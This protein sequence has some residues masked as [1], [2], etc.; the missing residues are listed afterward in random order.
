MRTAIAIWGASLLITMQPSAL[1]ASSTGHYIKTT[2][3][4]L[5]WLELAMHYSQKKQSGLQMSEML[6][7]DA[8]GYFKIKA[9][10]VT[11]DRAAVRCAQA[12][13]HHPLH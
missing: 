12:L 8:M 4:F 2:S 5:Q 11:I 13:L 6:R 9:A 7:L 1:K 3:V 10:S